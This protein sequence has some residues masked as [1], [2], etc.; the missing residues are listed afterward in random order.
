MR[1]DIVGLHA[2]LSRRRSVSTYTSLCCHNACMFCVEAPGGH[3]DI[4]ARSSAFVDVIWRSKT[5][6][7]SFALPSVSSTQPYHRLSNTIPRDD[8]A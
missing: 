7:N 5:S 1:H 4:L 3:D 6:V 2:S 8:R